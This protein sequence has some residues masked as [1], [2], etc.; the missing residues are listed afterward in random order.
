M[1]FMK[2]D[3]LWTK[4]GDFIGLSLQGV[5]RKFVSQKKKW[6]Y[7]SILSWEN[8]ADFYFLAILFPGHILEN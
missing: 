3:Y 5:M 4:Y 6:K 7:I 2:I 1:R 8:Q